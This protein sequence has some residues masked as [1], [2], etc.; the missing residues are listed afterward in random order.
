MKKFEA[1]MFDDINCYVYALAFPE[2]YN[3]RFKKFDPNNDSLKDR[4]FYIGKGKKIESLV[5]WKV[6]VMNKWQKMMK[7][8]MV[9]VKIILNMK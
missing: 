1:A 3:S 4:I 8:L 5:I 2:K 7:T 9:I 6:K